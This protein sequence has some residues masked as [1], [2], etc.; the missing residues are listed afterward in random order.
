L[1]EAATVLAAEA[2]APDLARAAAEP[3]PLAA[4]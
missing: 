3:L 2:L 4:E 1:D